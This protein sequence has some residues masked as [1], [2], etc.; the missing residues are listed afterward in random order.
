MERYGILCIE[1]H[2]ASVLVAGEKITVRNIGGEHRSVHTVSK[3]EF[4]LLLQCD[5][6]ISLPESETLRRLEKEGMIRPAPEGEETDPDLL[7]KSY[8]NRCVPNM[9][10]N[11]TERCN[12]NCRHCYEAVDNDIPR[13]EMPLERCRNLLAQAGDCGIQNIKITGGEPLMHRDFLD[14][15]RCVYENG[16]TVDRINTNGFFLTDTML[17]ELLALDRQILFNFS[18]DGIGYHDWMRGREGAEKDAL[19]K[20]RMLT[21]K[22]FPVRAAMTLNR[23]NKDAAAETMFRM[24]E[25]GVREF[26]IIRTSET[27]RW[28]MNAG[29]ACLT[30]EE[31]YDAMLELFRIYA[32][33]DR[34]I[35]LNVWQF[36]T[37]VSAQ[38]RYGMA[39]VLIAPEDFSPDLC[40]CGNCRETIIVRPDGSVF[41]CIASPGILQAHGM[42]FGNVFENGL[43]PVLQNS[44]YLSFVCKGVHVIAEN[45]PKC[46]ACPY[47]KQCLGGCRLGALGLGGDIFGHDPSKCLFF[48]KRYDKKL[49]EALPGFRCMQPVTVA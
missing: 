31:Y 41:P 32:A 42:E 7:R 44:G 15:V 13:S 16:M 11:I 29:D 4:E 19:Q 45:D 26:R 5:G 25:L 37:A 2:G 12:Y 24:E 47:F 18:F 6:K 10:I 48:E 46:A 27:P 1:Q 49:A 33:S 23:V 17:E 20:I 21:E 38:K 43:Q 36:A 14:I 22:G 40:L 34:K 39:M 9:A 30:V 3:E 8:E 28:V 35:N